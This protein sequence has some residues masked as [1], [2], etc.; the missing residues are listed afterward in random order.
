MCSKCLCAGLL[1]FGLALGQQQPAPDPQAAATA[2]HITAGKRIYDSQCALCH[3][4]GGVAGRGPALTSPK[5]RRAANGQELIE[6]I[7]QGVGGTGMPSFWF[8]G[9][10]PVFH[11]AA[12]V[13]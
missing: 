4:M 10:K 13:R 6:V 11:V 1:I 8:L 5:L 12:Y 9:E 7:V 2:E 3:G